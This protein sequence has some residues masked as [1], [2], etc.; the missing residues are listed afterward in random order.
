[1]KA[2]KITRNLVMVTYEFGNAIYIAPITGL[3]NKDTKV[4]DKKEDAEKWSVEDISKIGYWKALTG[5]KDL[6]L[7]QV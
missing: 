4:T 3:S 6:V 7:E 1:M 5:Y 2:N